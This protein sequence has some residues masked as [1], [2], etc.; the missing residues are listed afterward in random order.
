MRVR[1]A[2]LGSILIGAVLAAHAELA[3][4]TVLRSDMVAPYIAEG[5]VEAVRESQLAAQMPGRITAL[6]VKAGDTVKAGQELARIDERI[7]AD[8]MAAS[9]AQL[10]AA[11]NEY[12]RQRQLFE[13]QYI[14]Q[15]AM[16]RAEAQYKAVRAQA[17]SATTQ[18]Q[19]HTIVAPYAGVISAAPA[20]LGDMAMPGSPLFTIYDPQ[21]LRVTVRVPETIADTLRGD[22]AVAIEIPAAAQKI[23]SD[24][25]EILPTRDANTHTAEVRLALEA[26]IQNIRPGQF[27]RAH[28]PTRAAAATALWIPFS[29]VV[30]RSEFDAVYVI[31]K[32]G[33]PQL[34]QVRLGRHEGDTVEVLAGLDSGERIARDPLAAA[35]TSRVKANGAAQ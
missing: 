4:L 24:A 33:K 2:W 23:S 21:H 8:Q 5:V 31:T 13:K 7:A 15:A 29:A 30:H 35:Q 34:R 14:S 3:T 20:Q 1:E 17:N 19:L 26:S 6:N 18:T 12:E 10:D 16:D 32:E 9:R 25:I 11:K 28:L 22:A 27:A